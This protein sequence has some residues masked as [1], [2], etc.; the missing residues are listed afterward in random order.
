M[1]IK[2]GDH[3][4]IIGRNRPHLYWSIIAAQ[5][6]GAIPTP[7][8]QD[9][10][11]QEMI[12][13]ISHCSAKMAIVEN[14]EQVDKLIEIKKEIPLLKNIIYLEKMVEKIYLLNILS[15]YWLSCR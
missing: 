8:Y 4:S 11:A 3:I 13:P 10:V 14:Q 2:E 12:F 6:V 1:G 7:L 5:N 15:T 9:A